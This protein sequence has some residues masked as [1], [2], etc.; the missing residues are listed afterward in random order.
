MLDSELTK[1]PA[2]LRMIDEESSTNWTESNSPSDNIVTDKK[3]RQSIISLSYQPTQVDLKKI[4]EFEPNSGD[5]EVED[6]FD[7]FILN[8]F[9]SFSGSED[10]NDWLD[11][12]DKMFNLHKISRSLRYIAIPLLV[13]GDAKR[14]YI[15]NRNNIKSFDDFYEFLLTNYDVIE[16]NTYRSLSNPS[17]YSSHSNNV[18]VHQGQKW[19]TFIFSS[20]YT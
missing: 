13:E 1:E 5:N 19:S 10:V 11:N 8:N 4:S 9:N 15:R 17:S 2:R 6:G 12:T 14:K 18:K 20:K 7:S 3:R 16:H